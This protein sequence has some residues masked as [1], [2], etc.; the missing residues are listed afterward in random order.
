MSPQETSRTTTNHVCNP[1]PQLGRSK[2]RQAYALPTSHAPPAS[3]TSTSI[4]FGRRKNPHES[5]LVTRPPIVCRTERAE[6]INRT[7][8]SCKVRRICERNA[9]RGAG[10]ILS[11]PDGRFFC[12]RT[13]IGHDALMKRASHAPSLGVDARKPGLSRAIRH[14]A[15]AGGRG[16]IRTHGGRKPSPVFKTGALNHSTTRPAQCWAGEVALRRPRAQGRCPLSQSE[17]LPR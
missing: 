11:L 6:A 13:D 7:K 3:T 16:E 5:T 2:P 12:A 17:S 10:S 1:A 8:M 4:S 14:R 15:A 9:M